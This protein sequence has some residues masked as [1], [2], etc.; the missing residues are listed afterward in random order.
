MEFLAAFIVFLLAV[1]G[2]AVGVIFSDRKLAGSCG[3]VAADGTTL[4]DCL[5]EKKKQNLCPS[6]EGNELVKMAGLGW[7]KRKAK[8]GASPATGGDS[9]EV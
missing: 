9:I 2:M 1:A 8:G 3:G 4:G 7:P 6:E 5:C